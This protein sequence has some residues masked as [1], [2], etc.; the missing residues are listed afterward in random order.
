MKKP[1]KAKKKITSRI[2]L[3]NACK[4]AERT[5]KA[6]RE[7]RTVKEEDLHRRMTI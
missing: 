7:A 4:I 1:K 2:T 3:E 5:A 6:L